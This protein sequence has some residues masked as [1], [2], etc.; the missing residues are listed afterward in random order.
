MVAFVFGYSGFSY[1]HGMPSMSGELY[2]SDYRLVFIDHDYL[3]PSSRLAEMARNPIECHFLVSS[4]DVE[5]GSLDIA[6]GNRTG[7]QCI[8]P[9]RES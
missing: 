3:V 2:S 9:D 6:G 4:Y 7:R 5:Y 8:L 1:E